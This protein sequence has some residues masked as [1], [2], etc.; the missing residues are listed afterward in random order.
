MIPRSGTSR[1]CQIIRREL[2][3][4]FLFLLPLLI[5]VEALGN[6]ISNGGFEDA[7][8]G[9]LPGWEKLGGDGA[10]ADEQVRHSG[11]RSLRVS[12]PGGMRSNFIPY[13]GGRIRVT[14]WMRTEDVVTGPSAPWHK[15]ALQ[16][17]SYDRGKRAV[18]HFD[19][20]L[21]DGT[22]DWERKE[23]VAILSR[24]VAFVTVNCHIWGADAKGT[25]WFD[26][27][28]VE[29]LDSP[30]SLKRKPMDL[31]RA[32]LT[33]DF[34]KDLGEF[35]H[36]WIGSDVSYADRAAS[37]TQ[38]DAMRYARNFGF[39][40]I[41]LHDCVHDPH[42]Y[43]EDAGGN[44]VYRWDRFDRFVGAVVEAGCR[45]VIV[46][47][48]M[49]PELATHDDGVGYKNPYPPRGPKEYLK[50]QA[51]CR[52]VVAHCKAKWGDAIRDW[53]FEVWNEPEA[54]GYF[55][56]TLEEYLRI[57]DHAVTGATTADPKI[58]I[59][60]PGG[61]ATGWCRPFLEHCLAGRND[62]TG[63]TG[64][65][66]DFLSWHI[67]TVGVGIPA[68]D[69]L[70]VSLNDVRQIIRDLPTCK[71]LPLLITEWGCASSNN[72]VHDRPYDAAFRTMAV[73][74]F[75]DCGIHLALP[76]CLGE[77]PPH[78]HEGFMGGL[79]L[80]TKTTI[81]KPSFRA[82]ELLHRMVGR[83]VGCESSNDP[84]DGMA[85]LSPDGK[86]AWVIL[87]N[88]VEDPN[89]AAYETDVTI[90]LAGLRTGKWSRGVTAIA[91]GE[92]DPYVAWDKMG[93]PEKLTESQ[94]DA[95]LKAS[96]LPSPRSVPIAGDRISLKMPGYS[97]MLLE[98]RLESP[99]ESS[100][101][102]PSCEGPTA[103]SST[104][105]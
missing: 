77:G 93:R 24:D 100:I 57:Y 26:D 89:H 101:A 48:T 3:S 60:G 76:F 80:F 55:K 95:L 22:H 74:Y 104:Q 94:R 78:A 1:A 19:V 90:E 11:R 15:A 62:A 32:T 13:L 87:W 6:P 30:A 39:R 92:C 37:D 47:E 4:P 102:R 51:I 98:L 81:P 64:C 59:G 38:I 61:A 69:N 18:G 72:D 67:Y 84:V 96:Q 5:C 16:I 27:I 105:G 36:L 68:F 33:V 85:C 10:A 97:V 42:I 82:F 21:L 35:R 49:P 14:G 12:G 75:M 91:P 31:G 2:V 88:L 83:R 65:R 8:N 54:S 29:M 79:A 63:G 73:R 45:P 23:G 70:T 103:T 34:G 46:L 71:D 52:E 44:P 20:E 25:A 7:V 40:Y 41:R 17:I 50:W 53:Y 66:A 28:D 99:K 56:G 9:R 43:C 86:S 58:R